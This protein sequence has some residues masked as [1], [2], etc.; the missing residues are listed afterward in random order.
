M[1]RHYI[2]IAG[3]I[4]TGKT[5]TTE[6]VAKAM[7]NCSAFV[8]VR[9]TF[10]ARF[11]EDPNRYAFLN[12]LAYSL[13]YLEQAVEISKSTSHI[14]QDRSIYDTHQVFSQWRRETGLIFE[15][16]F[17]LLQRIF[18]A[19]DRLARPTLLVLLESSV[20]VALSRIIARDLPTELG[21]TNEFLSDL[22]LR[23][24]E[25]F[26]RF[27]LAPKLRLPTDTTSVDEVVD[28]ILTVLRRAC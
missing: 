18:R 20:D 23:Y 21:L 24:T 22:T 27:G 28:T 8:E 25:W 14:V 4:G 26:D 17:E 10:L 12:Q 19:S 7:P 3:S 6:A 5:T 13:Q 11:Y 15:D 1:K 2:V 16:E 9:D